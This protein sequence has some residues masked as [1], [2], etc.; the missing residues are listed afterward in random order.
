MILKKITGIVMIT[1]GILFFLLEYKAIPH[2]PKNP[3]KWDE[4][5]KKYIRPV[6]MSARIFLLLGLTFLLT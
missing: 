3:E 2:N 6:K 4:L 5:H 1:I